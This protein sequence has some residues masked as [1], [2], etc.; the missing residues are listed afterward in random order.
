M[1]EKLNLIV[2]VCDSFRQDHFGCYGGSPGL[3]PHFDALASES[4]VFDNAYA[5]SFPTLPCRVELFTGKFVFPY[6][7]WGP[8]PA[9]QVPFAERFQEFRYHTAIVADNL[10]VMRPGHGY[11]RGFDTR[12]H[13]RGQ[14]HDP[15]REKTPAHP[16]APWPAPREKL[17]QPDRVEQ[18]LLNI[19]DRRREEDYFAPRVMTAAGEWL[20]KNAK[21]EPFLLYIDCFDPHEPWD[22]PAEYVDPAITGEERI[23][24]PHL[25]WA[26]RYS[27]AEIA[28]MRELYAG[29][30]RMVDHWAG[31]FLRKIDELGLRD[32]TALIFLSDHGIFLG[33]HNLLGKVSKS[34]TSFNGWP[35]LREVGR[36]PLMMRIPGLAP[37]RARGFVHPGDVMPT[38]LELAG[39]PLPEGVTASSL[40]PMARGEEEKVRD[41][42]VTSWSFRG[43]RPYLPSCIRN[44]EW[45]LVW[46]RSGVRPRLHHLPDDPGEN[47]DVFE[48]N[49]GAA[50]DLHSRFI[51]F[52]EREEI[53]PRNYWP[54]RFFFTW[55]PGAPGF[56]TQQT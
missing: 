10:P 44:E 33:E 25:G 42:A 23:I 38:L 1:A 22:P 14:W 47:L 56:A 4:V 39:M 43:W 11:T 40:L 30:V 54:R 41:I 18:Y 55:S 9:S 28:S 49:R 24:Y 37:R 17:G 51:R 32:N 21:Q 48:K 5:G 50:R 26:D 7:T 15:W 19:G 6:V 31:R 3:T 52:I 36:I 46:W 35:P 16:G 13:I 34:R 12:I 27:P 8:F 2:L 45:S 29:E 20:E 53:T